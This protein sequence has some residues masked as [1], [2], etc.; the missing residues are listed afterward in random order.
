MAALARLLVALGTVLAPLCAFAQVEP[1]SSSSLV[2]GGGSIW[3]WL[4]EAFLFGAAG[5]VVLIGAYYLWELITPYSVKEQ[6]VKERNVAVA[7]VVAAFII[8]TALII[9]AAITPS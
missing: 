4:L 7:I 1:T 2:A 6:L 5:I 9:A 3:M 8:G